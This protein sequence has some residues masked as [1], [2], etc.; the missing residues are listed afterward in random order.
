MGMAQETR[1]RKRKDLPNAKVFQ[2]MAILLESGKARSLRDAAIKAV[3]AL[4]ISSDEAT[5]DSL[6]DRFRK[7]FK[8]VEVET[9][10]WARKKIDEKKVV[11]PAYTP[12]VPPSIGVGQY[13]PKKR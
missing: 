10:A 3:K 4:K 9:R 6:I 2:A 7:R 5:E 8:D 11:P 12:P 1:G 13:Y